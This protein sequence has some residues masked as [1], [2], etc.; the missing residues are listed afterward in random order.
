[1]GM[2]G[3]DTVLLVVIALLV[4]VGLLKGLTRLVIGVGA[5]VAAVLLATRFHPPVAAAIASAANLAEPMATVA[6]CAA[7]FLG[8]MLAG[9]LVAYVMRRTL[10]AAMLGWADRLA[11]AAVGLIAALL[12]A[13]LLLVPAVGRVPAAEGLLRESV[14]A[15]YVA[16]V[17]DMARHLVPD[18][19][20]AEYRERMDALRGYWLE[21][22]AAPSDPSGPPG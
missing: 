20:S 22:W 18:P 5:L 2:N 7:I 1:M 4:L 8:T 11:G 6:A 14:L 12:A 10:K 16:A 15:P 19:L 9:A 17:A 21:R 13:G 3:F